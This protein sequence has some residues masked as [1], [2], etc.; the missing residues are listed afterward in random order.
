M[1][2]LKKKSVYRLQGLLERWASA[3]YPIHSL[4]FVKA[5]ERVIP[6]R[7]W[8]CNPIES[9]WVCVCGWSPGRYIRK[10]LAKIITLINLMRRYVPLVCLT[11]YFKLSSNCPRRQRFNAVMFDIY[12]CLPLKKFSHLIYRL[13]GKFVQTTNLS[14]LFY[15]TE[16]STLTSNQNK[17]GASHDLQR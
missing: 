4:S 2:L 1:V 14:S 16:C 13:A 8:Q 7:A 3:T 15:G 5:E 9:R 11:R 17:R 6:W 12:P 10:D